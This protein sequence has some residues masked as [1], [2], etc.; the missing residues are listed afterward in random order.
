[1]PRNT[2]ILVVS[3]LSLTACCKHGPGNTPIVPVDG[4]P[5]ATPN[6]L[7]FGTIDTGTSK[8][9]GLT[10]TNVGT[11]LLNVQSASISGDSSFSMAP[12]T[13]QTLEQGGSFTL[14][15]TCTPQSDGAHQGTLTFLSDSTEKPS[16]AVPLT[17][18]AFAY[19]IQVVP[20]ELDF[21]E[22][23]VGTTSAQQQITV[24]NNASAPETITVG[25]VSA[26]TGSNSGDFQISGQMG[27]QANVPPGGFFTITVVF[28]PTI[29]GPETAQLPITACASGCPPVSVALTGTGID[30]QIVLLDFDTGQPYVS[31]TQVTSGGDT[32][33]VVAIAN[34]L[35]ATAQTMLTAT[36]NPCSNQ[37]PGPCL[38][39]G[40]NDGF[41]LTPTNANWVPVPAAWP[42][43]LTPGSA[44]S[45]AYFI[46]SFTPPSGSNSASDVADVDYT[47][48]PA[49]QKIAKLPLSAGEAGS[50][51]QLVTATPSSVP[52]GTVLAGQV[53]TQVV[54]LTNGG[55]QLCQL[56]NVGINPND[57]YNEFGLTGGTITQLSLSP[58][59]SQQL[60]VT[61]TPSAGTPPLLR[62]ADLSMTTSDATRPTITVP[63]SG[64]LQNK[65]YAPTAWP[66]WHHDNGNSGYTTADT[67]GNQGHMAWKVSIGVP[68][69]VTGSKSELA[70]YIDSP[71]IGQD[72]NT[73]DD[74]VYMLGY[75]T[76]NI[77]N[78]YNNV[79]PGSGQFVAVDGPS[80]N[81]LWTAQVTGP[82]N[83]AQE[84]TPT[85]VADGSIFLMTGGE[86]TSYPEFFHISPTGS[87]LWSGVQ[88]LTGA[89]A[90]CTFDPTGA[91]DCTKQ[92]P[93]G[94]KINDGFD[95][96]PGFDNNGVLYL[97]DD[98][99]PACDTYSSS[100]AQPVL[101]WSTTET[102]VPAHVESFSAALTS[103]SESVFSYGGYVLAFNATGAQMW[104]IG[105]GNGLMTNGWKA[106]G[107]GGSC[108]NDS[109]GSP[110]IDGSETD[111][112]VAFGGF[113]PSCSNIIG[114]IAGVNLATGHQDWGTYLAGG[115][116]GYPP[117]AAPPAA[118][119]NTN[120][121]GSALVSYSSPASMGNGNWVMGWI[122]GVYAIAPPS[123]G[124]GLA[125]VLWHYPTGLVLSSPAVGGDGTVFVG[126]SDGNFYAINGSNG[127]L[128]WKYPVGAAVN[129]SPAIGSD[130]S[131]YFAADDGNLYALR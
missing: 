63:L 20:V 4:L 96:C 90:A 95:T 126:S 54:T 5:S 35:P 19:S 44:N 48:G 123:G 71:A 121:Y 21:G 82:E 76:Y 101:Q 10:L 103:T 17:C 53:G 45:V 78:V 64:T 26:S 8:K 61:F 127:T 67:S 58:G 110:A 30:T 86:Q 115:G 106:K 42:G 120:G 14:S 89:I 128:K 92:V 73:K 16:Y 41:S 94:F 9:L 91:N 50:P 81:T 56:S 70:T 3:A 99:Q 75:G 118:P 18:T 129:S 29:T 46:V 83:S 74:V 38:E 107:S 36:L 7:D 23:Q 15:V 33:H 60:T 47:V 57:A 97:F 52:F 85:I 43:T 80:G 66:K 40:G 6:P 68:V 112:V 88:A 69:G 124:T 65:A 104:G 49:P 108:E 72:T 31:F 62:K 24:T 111:A 119:Y 102:D 13:K 77:N 51:C 109:K 25:S 130:G 100:T 28:A 105:T 98:D 116:A 32:A 79:A 55:P 27:V 117:A 131:V 125:T 11:G 37:P 22:I 12:L 87:I 1:M 113:D 84:A 34:A 59:Q 39:T 122:D 2:L 93:A 114:G